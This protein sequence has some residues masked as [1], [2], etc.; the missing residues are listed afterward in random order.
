MSN[1]LVFK[2]ELTRYETGD[3]LCYYS[4]NKSFSSIE[5]GLLSLSN[6]SEKTFTNVDFVYVENKVIDTTIKITLDRTD[7]NGG[8]VD[9]VISG[10][11][12]VC[13]YANI[14]EVTILSQSD[15]TKVFYV[16]GKK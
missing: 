5:S 16:I 7:D 15:S 3:V 6:L 4:I 10:I 14:K 13:F 8:A 2:G 11:G 12:A 9:L 1:T